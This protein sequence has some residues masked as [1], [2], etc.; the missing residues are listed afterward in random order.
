MTFE[1]GI[2]C[3]YLREFFYQRLLYLEKLR[4]HIDCLFERL[5]LIEMN[6]GQF[7]RVLVYTRTAYLSKSAVTAILIEF[8]LFDIRNYEEFLLYSEYM[9]ENAGSQ[10]NVSQTTRTC[11]ACKTLTYAVYYFCPN[12]GKQ[13]RAKPLSTSISKQIGVYLLSVFVPPFGLWP[14]FK[15]LMQK[16]MKA[17][18][19]GLTA[20]IL[21]VLSLV[22]TTYY[23]IGF[24][25]K[26][27]QFIG[28]SS[29]DQLQL[30]Y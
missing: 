10:G 25:S 11:P 27:N 22:I 7:H 12:C 26:L 16:D 14:A 17:K 30:Q 23:T 15:Y 4:N 13:L 18:A 28:L 21:T 5:D 6:N 9:E 20:I 8:I 2:L 24:F 29:Q 1:C 19:V 3:F